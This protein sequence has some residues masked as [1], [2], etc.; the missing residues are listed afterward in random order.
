MSEKEETISIKEPLA[1]ISDRIIAT[2]IDFLVVDVIFFICL[3]LPFAFNISFVFT[4]IPALEIL[5]FIF[6]PLMGVIAAVASAMYF[7]YWPIKTHG[8]TLGKKIMGIRLMIISDFKKGTLRYFTREDFALST[9]RFFFS[10]IDMQLFGGLGMIFMSRSPIIQTF[11]DKKLATVV[12]E[13]EDLTPEEI[14]KRITNQQN[15]NKESKE[16]ESTKK[17]AKNEDEKQ[18]NEN[19]SEVTLKNEIEE[20]AEEI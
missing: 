19:S 2:I 18:N 3:A 17:E 8:S 9:K 12:I 20:N 7:I 11:A 1:S 5:L 15:N 4:S 16:N 6:W 10:F 14:A 13:D